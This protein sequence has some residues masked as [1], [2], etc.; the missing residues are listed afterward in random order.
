MK[1]IRENAFETN[2]SSSHSISLGKELGKD[3]VLDTIYPDQEGKIVI[4]DGDY[5]W[6]FYKTNDAIEKA[7]YALTDFKEKQDLIEL[8]EEVIKEHTDCKEVVFIQEGGYIDH[9]S[10]GTCPTTKET[11]KDFIFNKNSWLFTGNDNSSI[12]K[13]FY[14]TDTYN[15]DGSITPVVYKYELKIVGVKQSIKFTEYPS[16]ED[17]VDGLENLLNRS[18][19][20]ELDQIVINPN[21]MSLFS[22]G[23]NVFEF[24]DYRMP[25][26]VENK[27]IYFVTKK[28]PILAKP[29]HEYTYEERKEI[30]R[31]FYLLPDNHKKATFYIREI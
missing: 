30:E 5:G 16:N 21:I 20:N 29:Y 8:L 10:D 6:E 2:S 4:A 18:Y 19:V 23:K 7:S 31:A 12:E 14:K 26:D 3:F 27:T 13:S 24:S 28:E 25:I 15:A 9:Q 11:L 22:R 17:I 1:L